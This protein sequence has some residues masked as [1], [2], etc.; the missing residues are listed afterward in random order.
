MIFTYP[1]LLSCIDIFRKS[2][3]LPISCI[4][5]FKKE[6]EKGWLKQVCKRTE[7]IHVVEEMKKRDREESGTGKKSE[8]KRSKTLPLHL[9]LQQS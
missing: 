3:I 2:S 8:E 1:S 9:Y 7:E 4:D 5:I 6:T